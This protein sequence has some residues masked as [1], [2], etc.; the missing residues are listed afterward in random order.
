MEAVMAQRNLGHRAI[1]L[2]MFLAL[3]VC[4]LPT[5][6]R[7][8]AT[9]TLSGYVPDPTGAAIVQATVTATL[10]KQNLTRTAESSAEGF[11]NFAALPPGVYTLAAEKSGFQRL[12][13]TDVVLTVNQNLR[14]DISMELGAVTEA[15]TVTADAA[16]V[17]TRSP[18]G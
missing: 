15:V 11:Y 18:T 1:F 14:V 9:A 16:L 17:D 6:L 8:Q 4:A 2:G 12:V 3:R 5:D 13:Q 10:V 7:A